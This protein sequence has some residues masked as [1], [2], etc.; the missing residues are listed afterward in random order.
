MEVKSGR[1]GGKQK[2]VREK[3]EDSEVEQ[4]K[5]GRKIETAAEKRGK[6]GME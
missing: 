4:K 5:I 3:E 6:W 1:N 2:W